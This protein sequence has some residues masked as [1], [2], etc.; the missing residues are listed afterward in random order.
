MTTITDFQI[1]STRSRKPIATLGLWLSVGLSILAAVFAVQLALF[2][3]AGNFGD[4]LT[5]NG[6]QLF[7]VPVVFYI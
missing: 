4:L 1:A 3:V 7:W 6:W 2:F 5:R